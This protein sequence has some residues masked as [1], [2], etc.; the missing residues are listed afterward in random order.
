MT[1]YLEIAGSN[2]TCS[3]TFTNFRPFLPF[4]ICAQF[5]LFS[6]TITLVLTNTAGAAKVPFESDQGPFF[7]HGKFSGSKKIRPIIFLLMFCRLS[8]HI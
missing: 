4:L 5:V 6:C 8:C 3:K 1:S 7:S 2:R